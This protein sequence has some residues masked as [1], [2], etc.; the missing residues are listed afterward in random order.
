MKKSY[1]IISVISLLVIVFAIISISL[2]NDTKKDKRNEENPNNIKEQEPKEGDTNMEET[3]SIKVI[4]NNKEMSATLINTQTTQEFLEKLPMTITMN[5][6]N[7]NEKYYY[8]NSELSSSPESIN[9]IYAG[10]IMLYQNNCLVLFYKNFTTSYK[11]T[12][13]GHLD[14]PSELKGLITDDDLE[15]TFLK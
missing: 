13:I 5:E 6:L 11:Y 9:R 2:I 12:K 3:I 1:I 8:F 7:D 10:D 4:I 14:N 15:V